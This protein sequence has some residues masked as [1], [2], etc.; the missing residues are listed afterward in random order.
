M[1]I[2]RSE[3][4]LEAQVPLLSPILTPNTPYDW[5]YTTTAQPGLNGR[6]I[7]FPRGKILGGSASISTSDHMSVRKT[8]I[9]DHADFLIYGRGSTDDF[10]N[11]A[12]IS[13]DS[14]WGWDNMYQYAL[15]VR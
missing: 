2:C 14:G 10:N 4:I 5:N 3:G 7:P 6:A 8:S 13:G 15:K 1:L 9:H 12:K 11:Y